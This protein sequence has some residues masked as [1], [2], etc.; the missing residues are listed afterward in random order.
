MD[1]VTLPY[2]P[3]GYTG[4]NLLRGCI[5]LH[6]HASPEVVPGPVDD[7]ATARLASEMGMK[8]FVLKPFLWPTVRVAQLV[9]S[10]V[11]GINV[12]GGMVLNTLTGG[13]S[14]PLVD[15][16]GRLGAKVVWMPTWSAANDIK[17][18][19]FSRALKT[20]L[21]H[22]DRYP[23]QGLSAV[24]GDG[25]LIPEVV[26]I[27]RLVKQYDMVLCTGH[28]SVQE[29]KCIAKEALSCGFRKLVFSHPLS[30]SVGASLQDMKE[31]AEMGAYIEHCAIAASPMLQHVK[32]DTFVEIISAIGPDRTLLTTDVTH[33]YNPPG[34]IM[35]QG[36]LASLLELG[37]ERKDLWKMA[38]RNPAVL[39]NLEVEDE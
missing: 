5:D 15:A 1:K 22:L 26:D 10:C 30:R 19:G 11:P 34:P 9:Q 37:L 4:E 12:Y 31:M 16:A 3:K 25:A 38:K 39:L 7:L 8:A 6:V 29:S 27:L 2:I 13:F 20:F 21:H 28:L 18:G 33:P 24:T 36:F 14:P 35:M 23:V 17:R 32:M